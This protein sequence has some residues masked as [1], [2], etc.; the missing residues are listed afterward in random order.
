[1]GRRDKSRDRAIE[2]AETNKA[3]AIE[4]APIGATS[5]SAEVPAQICAP[6]RHFIRRT[7]APNGELIG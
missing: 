7:Y 5:S 4:V 2:D 1:M 6:E 3:A